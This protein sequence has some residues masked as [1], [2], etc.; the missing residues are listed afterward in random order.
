MTFDEMQD[1]LHELSYPDYIF[2]I[3][4]DSRGSIYLQAIYFEPDIVTGEE[5]RQV[6]R[7]WFLSPEM[8]KSEIVQTAFK[9]IMTSMEHRAR[10]HFKYKGQRIFGPHYDVEALVDLCKAK[11]LDYRGR[12]KAGT[13]GRE[14]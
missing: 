4:E 7:R 5:E 11:K 1:I 2:G 10:E 14:K 3:V 12:V 13:H 9:C 6:T 8:V